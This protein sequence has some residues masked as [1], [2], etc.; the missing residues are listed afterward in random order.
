MTDKKAGKKL[1]LLS[2]PIFLAL[3][4]L[5]LSHR[6]V[7]SAGPDSKSRDVKSAQTVVGT[8]ASD[9]ARPRQP[10]IIRLDGQPLV[11]HAVALK[12]AHVQHDSRRERRKLTVDHQLNHTYL[13]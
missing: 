6:I 8:V 7:F 5:F 13:N 10:Y 11:S 2:F 9:R 1:I 3:C 4:S 12:M